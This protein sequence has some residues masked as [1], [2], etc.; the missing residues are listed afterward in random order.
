[1]W[2]KGIG[3]KQHSVLH[4]SVDDTAKSAC[5]NVLENDRI[6]EREGQQ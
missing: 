4:L 5:T 2:K 6:T 1:M 3:L